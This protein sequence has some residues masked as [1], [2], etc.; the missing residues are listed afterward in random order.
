MYYIDKHSKQQIQHE[1]K[2]AFGLFGHKTI[3]ICAGT[4]NP[5][6]KKRHVFVVYYAANWNAWFDNFILSSQ[7]FR[8]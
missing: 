6:F 1:Y 7:L 5:V 8:Y 4:T 2:N 3:A